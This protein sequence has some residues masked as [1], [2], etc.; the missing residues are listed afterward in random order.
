MPCQQRHCGGWPAQPGCILQAAAGA[1]R[2]RRCMNVLSK[3]DNFAV[4]TSKDKNHDGRIYCTL[5]HI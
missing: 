3:R 4:G 2:H 1:I 5:N